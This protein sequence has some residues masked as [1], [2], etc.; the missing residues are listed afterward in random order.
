M[1]YSFRLQVNEHIIF[2]VTEHA[3]PTQDGAADEQ[4]RNLRSRANCLWSPSTLEGSWGTTEEDI[5]TFE[6]MV[7]NPQVQG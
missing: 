6:Q 7:H 5:A 4:E 2:T 3:K 1:Q